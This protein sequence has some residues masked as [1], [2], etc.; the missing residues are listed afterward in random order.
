METALLEDRTPLIANGFEVIPAGS[1]KFKTTD[2][3]AMYFEIYEPAL[4]EAEVPKIALGLQVRVFDAKG[5]L[6]SDSGGFRIPS[7]REGWESSDFVCG[8]DSGGDVS[9]RGR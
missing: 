3:A 7:S 6:K 1:A 9:S 4:M 2:K 5:A 8:T